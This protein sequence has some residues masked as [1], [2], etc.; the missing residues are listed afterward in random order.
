MPKKP[1]KRTR[2][3][4]IRVT[5][6][7]LETMKSRFGSKQ[8]STVLR[9]Y[10]LKSELPRRSSKPDE[11]TLCALARIGNNLNQIARSLNSTKGQSLDKMEL[12]LALAELN[13]QAKAI[14]A[15]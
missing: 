4:E 9:D 11:K 8:F 2:K 13:Q 6:S 14:N 10:L 15:R 5:D 7:E 12:I 3:I 1:D